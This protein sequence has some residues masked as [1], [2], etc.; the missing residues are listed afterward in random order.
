MSQHIKADHFFVAD[1]FPNNELMQWNIKHI[2]LPQAHSDNG[3]TPRGIGSILA[4]IEGYDFISYLD[5]DNWFHP[6]HLSTLVELWEKNNVD[7]CASF[8]TI[9]TL[10]GS[11]INVQEKDEI[12]L[13]H[14]DTSCL[15]LHRNSFR[16]LDIWLNM[17]KKLSPICDRVFYAG[18]KHYKYKFGFTKQKT[19][20]FR[21]QY[22]GH[23][24]AAK[25][26]PPEGAKG[27]IGKEPYQWLLTPDGIKEAVDML[28]YFPI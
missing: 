22:A 16:A 18:L 28:G 26:T 1:G 3:N 8:R 10:E 19:I 9:H 7:V 15:L 5:A 25:L 27:N 6:N 13:S 2:S 20:A 21:S 4:K 12:S 24:I 23:Y 17:P 11:E 14:I